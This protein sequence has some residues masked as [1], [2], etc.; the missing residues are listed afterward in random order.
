MRHFFVHRPITVFGM[1]AAI[2]SVVYG[3]GYATHSTGYVDTVLYRN[4]NGLVEPAVFG[5][6]LIA[7]GLPLMF[8]FVTNKFSWVSRL[9]TVQSVAWLFAFFMY[10][11]YG[12]WLLGAG[13]AL[14]WTLISGYTAFAYKNQ[15]RIL[16]ELL[17]ERL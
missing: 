15:D 14:M 17:D 3:I 2:H 13:M 9:S 16:R 6:F 8:A 4:I 7:I 11:L 12:S 10:A 5:V 1:I